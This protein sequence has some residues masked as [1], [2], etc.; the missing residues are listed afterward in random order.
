MT[1]RQIVS[2]DDYAKLKA[3]NKLNRIENDILGK[4]NLKLRI[5]LGNAIYYKWFSIGVIAFVLSWVSF[6]I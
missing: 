1:D 5:E 2:T 3:E 6:N 4:E